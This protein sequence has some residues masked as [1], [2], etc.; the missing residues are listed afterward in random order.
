MKRADIKVGESYYID[1]SNYLLGRSRV[2]VLEIGVE[3][4][5]RGTRNDG[6]R[7]LVERFVGASYSRIK[8]GDERMVATRAILRPWTADDDRTVDN[9]EARHVLVERLR[10]RVKNVPGLDASY[11][12]LEI[13]LDQAE[14]FLDRA[15]VPR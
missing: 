15:G 8:N 2:K 4:G 14:A 3:R 6:V 11:R 9:D 7:V 10:A 1:R 12:S 13:E 5:Y